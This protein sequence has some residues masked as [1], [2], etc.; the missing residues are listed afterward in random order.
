MWTWNQAGEVAIYGILTVFVILTLLT[1]LVRLSGMVLSRIDKRRK[2]TGMG[3]GD[4]DKR[5]D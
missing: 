5:G 1:V 4:T 3:K 2:S